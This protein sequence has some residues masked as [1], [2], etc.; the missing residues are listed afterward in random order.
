MP[1]KT[2]QCY[3]MF[4]YSIMYVLISQWLSIYPSKHN[5]LYVQHCSKGIL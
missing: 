4:V 2:M 5:K 1:N 3:V